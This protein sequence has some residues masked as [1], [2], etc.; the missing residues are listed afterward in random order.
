MV[1]AEP[2]TPLGLSG[3]PRLFPRQ[4]QAHTVL[5]RKL[6]NSFKSLALMVSLSF[7]KALCGSLLPAEES[8]GSSTWHLGSSVGWIWPAFPN[9]PPSHPATSHK[10]P[11]PVAEGLC[12]FA[13]ALS[14]SWAHCTSTQP[15]RASS[16]T[17]SGGD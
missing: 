1:S 2:L 14:Q 7:S 5:I 12:A 10:V 8:P 17:S 13:H 6:S 11:P 3:E 15:S 4:S 9:L 16:T